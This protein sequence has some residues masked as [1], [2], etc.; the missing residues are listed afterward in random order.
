MGGDTS[1]AWQEI[2]A[3]SPCV[4]LEYKNMLVQHVT[5]FQDSLRSRPLLGAIGRSG[6]ALAIYK[7][8][9]AH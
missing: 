1:S 2:A 4:Q 6:A 3:L 7:M 5:T 8:L 9:V